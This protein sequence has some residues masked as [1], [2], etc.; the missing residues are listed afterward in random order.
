LSGGPLLEF[1]VDGTEIG[2]TVQLPATGGTVEVRTIANSVLPVHTLQIV[3]N[4]QV[5]AQ[6]DAP[7]SSGSRSLSLNARLPITTRSWLTARVS[8]PNYAPV[9]H[10]DVWSRGVFAHTSPIYVACGDEWTIADPAGLQYML[11]LVG[12]SLDYIRTL[13]PRRRPGTHQRGVAAAANPDAESNRHDDANTAGDRHADTDGHA[14]PA[15]ALGARGRQSH[16]KSAG[17]QGWRLLRRMHDMGR[18]GSQKEGRG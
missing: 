6:T 3:Q 13:S 11:T 8:G 16:C 1:S 17:S 14:D 9:A 10:H 5:V 12:G 4:G 18:A 2:D 7:A 15:A